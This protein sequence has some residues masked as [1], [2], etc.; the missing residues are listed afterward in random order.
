MWWQC[1]LQCCEEAL[2]QFARLHDYKLERIWRKSVQS[3]GSFMDL[4]LLFRIIC[5]LPAFVCFLEVR[6]LL[7]SKLTTKGQILARIDFAPALREST[8]DLNKTKTMRTLLLLF[9]ALQVFQTN[10]QTSTH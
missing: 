10:G 4:Y 8:F 1:I 3:A 5:L 6:T 7:L 9:L 2:L